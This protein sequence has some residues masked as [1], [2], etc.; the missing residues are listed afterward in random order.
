MS[1]I[2]AQGLMG[3]G[4][5]TQGWSSPSPSPSMITQGLL[6]P[7]VL[8]QGLVGAHNVYAMTPSGG[9]VDGGTAAPQALHAGSASGGLEIGAK[10][11]GFS[12]AR[13]LAAAGLSLSGSARPTTWSSVICIGGLG[14]GSSA[15]WRTMLTTAAHGGV[16]L[17]GQI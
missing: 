15:R 12:R 3:G 9:S 6:G 8:L 16:S 11:W 17:G 14:L 10:G 1:L 2:M 13:I 5:L 4:L 7:Q